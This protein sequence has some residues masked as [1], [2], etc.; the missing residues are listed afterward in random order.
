MKRFWQYEIFLIVKVYT[1][2]ELYRSNNRKSHRDC[3]YKLYLSKISHIVI[4]ISEKQVRTNYPKLMAQLIVQNLMNNT[5]NVPP[6][7]H[8]HF[9]LCYYTKVKFWELTA[10]IVCFRNTCWLGGC[11]SR[12]YTGL[13]PRHRGDTDRTSW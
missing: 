4:I 8:H 3:R 10:S 13:L 9:C 2:S 7:L 5:L 12:S 1:V 6:S 11:W